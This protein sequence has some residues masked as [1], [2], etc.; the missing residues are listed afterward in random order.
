MQ[1]EL[2]HTVILQD[3]LLNKKKIRLNITYHNLYISFPR[4]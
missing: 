1:H 2:T 4:Q 3:K